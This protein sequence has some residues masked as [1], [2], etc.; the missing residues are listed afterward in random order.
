MSLCNRHH[1]TRPDR[2]SKQT[3]LF[4]DINKLVY[5]LLMSF[6]PLFT[7]KN[8]V[9]LL[10]SDSDDYSPVCSEAEEDLT[11]LDLSTKSIEQSPNFPDLDET[12]V[13]Q[14]LLDEGS[15]IRLL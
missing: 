14:E 8:F 13:N 3:V 9:E 5:L 11:V 15:R 4:R 7:V 2:L 10:E 1:T 6:I 12:L